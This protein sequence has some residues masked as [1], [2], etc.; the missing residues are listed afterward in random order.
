MF[1]SSH[2]WLL[3]TF[4]KEVTKILGNLCLQCARQ[5]GQDKKSDQNTKTKR[6]KYGMNETL[7]MT[8]DLVFG[9]ALQYSG[10]S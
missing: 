7:G 6:Q 1:R 9:T 2:F 10:Q 3:V 8:C 5:D 4:G